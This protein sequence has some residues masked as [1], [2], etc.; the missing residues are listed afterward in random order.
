L[1][2]AAQQRLSAWARGAETARAKLESFLL[3]FF[4]KEAFPFYPSRQDP[5]IALD[6]R[7]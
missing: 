5:S 2:K 7:A 3:P 1:K 6:E 4:K